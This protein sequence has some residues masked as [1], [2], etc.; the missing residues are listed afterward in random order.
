MDSQEW[1]QILARTYLSRGTINFTATSVKLYH[2]L[3]P[4]SRSVVEFINYNC[5]SLKLRAGC[6]EARYILNS[7]QDQNLSTKISLTFVLAVGG[8]VLV[9]RG[10]Q[11]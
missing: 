9:A 4:P 7:K 3:F 5:I 1:G 6:S 11:G 8:I 10:L 2:L